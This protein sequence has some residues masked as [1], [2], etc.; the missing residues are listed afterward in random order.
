MH[1]QI[2]VDHRVLGQ[3]V[4]G[5]EFAVCREVEAFN[6]LGVALVD[7]LVGK[8]FRVGDAFLERLDHESFGV[9]H[10]FETMRLHGVVEEPRIIDEFLDRTNLADIGEVIFRISLHHRLLLDA[11]KRLVEITGNQVVTHI[12]IDHARLHSTGWS[13]SRYP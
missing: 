8:A 13:V 3:G 6:K 5:R 11:L 2:E 4:G 9:G 7:Q 1:T 12:R 10:V